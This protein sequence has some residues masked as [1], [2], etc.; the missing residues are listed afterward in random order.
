MPTKRE[1]WFEVL[2]ESGGDIERLLS[3]R[4]WA[5]AFHR[6]L[7]APWRESKDT[8]AEAEAKL[9]SRVE[10]HLRNGKST[11]P[12]ALMTALAEHPELYQ[13]ALSSNGSATRA[14]SRT[15]TTPKK[16]TAAGR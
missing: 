14:T 9:R 16:E 13:T 5:K 3:D 11:G 15:T 4:S 10:H 8:A 2:E 12:D 1:I 7:R 6:I